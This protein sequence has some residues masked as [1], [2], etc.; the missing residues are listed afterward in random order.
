MSKKH[1]YQPGDLLI[2]YWLCKGELINVAR[3][4]VIDKEEVIHCSIRDVGYTSY[5]C[6]IMYTHD[7]WK[8][9]DNSGLLDVGLIYEIVHWNDMDAIMSWAPTDRL[10]VV[11]SG[12]SWED[13]D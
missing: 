12:L 4:L 9:E 2:E 13:V 5:K 11:Q 8:R 1:I 10:D 6:Y 7:P 3:Y